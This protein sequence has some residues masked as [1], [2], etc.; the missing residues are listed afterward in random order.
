MNKINSL[1]ITASLLTLSHAGFAAQTDNDRYK[2]IV[3]AYV[4]ETNR[5]EQGFSPKT[6]DIAVVADHQKRLTKEQNS[7]KASWMPAILKTIGTGFGIDAGIS[8]TYAIIN[9]FPYESV[10]PIRKAL[11]YSYKAIYPISEPLTQ[12]TDII[13]NPLSD[14]LYSMHYDYHKISKGTYLAGQSSILAGTSLFS[15]AI[16]T[17]LF[18]KANSYQEEIERLEKEIELDA[19]ITRLIL[20]MI[21]I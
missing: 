7:Y 16:A 1:L 10:R 9:F 20:D 5:F 15:A 4:P 6:G 18:K 3:A 21:K 13:T 8:A 19:D 2:E 11:K 14:E 17:Y 12:L